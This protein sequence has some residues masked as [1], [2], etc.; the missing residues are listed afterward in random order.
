MLDESFN[1]IKAIIADGGCCGNVINYVRQ[2]FRYITN[3][4]T[5]IKSEQWS[6]GLIMMAVVPQLWIINRIF[7]RNGQ[8]V[9]YQTFNKKIKQA[10]SFLAIIF[11]IITKMLF[12]Y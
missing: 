3:S 6:T 4:A 5:Q 9:R 11:L 8:I 1:S 12:W 7:G 2:K 10:L